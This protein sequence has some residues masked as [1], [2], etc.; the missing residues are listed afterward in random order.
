MIFAPHIYSAVNTIEYGEFVKKTTF[1]DYLLIGLKV[2]L[3]TFVAA[4]LGVLIYILVGPAKMM[5]NT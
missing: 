2:I 4:G 3:Y 1:W 5:K